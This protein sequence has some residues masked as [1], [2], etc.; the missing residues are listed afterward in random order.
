[1]VEFCQS[2]GV[3]VMGYSPFGSL[4]ARHGSTV[5][6]PKIDDPVLSSIAQKYGKTTPQIVLRWQVSI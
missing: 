2:E 3:V 5:E 6:G 1:M 4:V